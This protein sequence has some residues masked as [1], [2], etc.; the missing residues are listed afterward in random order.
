MNWTETEQ[1]FISPVSPQTGPVRIDWCTKAE[2]AFVFSFT[3]YGFAK[4]LSAPL[5]HLARRSVLKTK[6]ISRKLITT[7]K[8]LSQ[9]VGQSV[10]INNQTDYVYKHVDRSENFFTFGNWS[11]A[12]AH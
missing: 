5:V 12:H 7:A 3:K 8:G 4:Y 1:K 11:N 6:I 2:I 10:Q 9:I